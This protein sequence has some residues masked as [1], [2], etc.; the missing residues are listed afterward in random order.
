MSSHLVSPITLNCLLATNCIPEKYFFFY[1]KV[2][3]NAY[4]LHVFGQNQVYLPWKINSC[5]LRILTSASVEIYV[6][7]AKIV[8]YI[9]R[10]AL[11]NKCIN[12]ITWKYEFQKLQKIFWTA[13]RK[14][15]CD[16]FFNL[17]GGIK[18][19]TKLLSRCK[20]CIYCH[21]VNQNSKQDNNFSTV[22]EYYS[23]MSFAMQNH[24]I[25]FINGF[26]LNLTR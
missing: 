25:P 13:G 15:Y 21:P 8:W 1:N 16:E 26:A 3:I 2:P 9:R 7:N 6:A 24:R 18:I 19:N 11:E 5:C 4:L 14:S 10:N 23:C 22:S 17:P 20:F 12:I